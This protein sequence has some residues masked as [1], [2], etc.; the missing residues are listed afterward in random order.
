MKKLMTT[1]CALALAFAWG[2]GP[3]LAADDTVK[4]KGER[5]KDK[6]ETTG[7]N[8][9]DKLKDAG[10][11]TKDKLKSAGEKVKD[12]TVETKD[13]VKGAF[14]RDKDHVASSDVTSA[15]QALKDKGFDPG[16][17]DG[18]MGPRTHAAISDFQKKEGLKVTGRL[19]RETK[20]HLTGTATTSSTTTPSTTTA[21]AASPA[22]GGTTTAPGTPADTTAPKSQTR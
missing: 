4:D 13:K 6:L 9:K 2:A 10:E 21:P 22:T 17:I 3:A 20:S 5:A 12:K 18:R 1:A 15:Q 16:P 11:T 19:D 14:K 8:T 7:E